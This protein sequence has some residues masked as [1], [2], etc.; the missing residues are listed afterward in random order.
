MGEAVTVKM[1]DLIKSS[2]TW[3]NFLDQTTFHGVK[4]I[5]NLKYSL[6]RRVIWAMIVISSTSLFL[7]QVTRRTLLYEKKETTVNVKVL[8]TGE[9]AF[10]S[11]TICNQNKFRF[12][13]FPFITLNYNKSI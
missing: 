11:T 7:Y 13:F 10:P 8:Y 4:N 12:S 6:V 5:I 9:L 2:K 1:D 3:R